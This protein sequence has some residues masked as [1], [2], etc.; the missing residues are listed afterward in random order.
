MY[1]MIIVDDEVELRE[2]ISS[3]FPWDSLQIR[4]VGIF[5][6]GR[7]AY[8]YLKEHPVD[9]VLTDIK[10]PFMDGLELIEKA[11]KLSLSTCYV[12]LSGYREFEYA[13]K[14]MHLGVKDYIVKPTKYSQIY[15]VF[16]GITAELGHKKKIAIS[17][18]PSVIADIKNYIQAHY[19]E[20]TLES[21][22]D[23]VHL[24][25][26]YLSTFFKQQTGV[27]FSDYLLGLKMEI[28]VTLLERGNQP[29]KEIGEA[30]GYTNPNSFTRAFRQYYLCSPKEYRRKSGAYDGR[31]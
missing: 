25:P 31:R 6:N 15:E 24:N 23:Y 13:K 28:A 1:E 14:G 20:A 17:E 3:Y 8:A 2:G 7:T 12:I 29:I 26:Y 30:I 10:M 18:D 4:I 21:T 19:A 16:S 9:I 22:A 11:K 5:E 27:K